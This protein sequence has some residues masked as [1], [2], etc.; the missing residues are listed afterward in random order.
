MQTGSALRI[1]IKIGQGEL[2][3]WHLWLPKAPRAV[4]VETRVNLARL[5]DARVAHEN[6]LTEIKNLYLTFPMS[7]SERLALAFE[8]L[9]QA[10]LGLM[11]EVFDQTLD[12][13]TDDPE[14]LP[15]LEQLAKT[16]RGLQTR[17]PAGANTPL[18]IEIDA[19]L[20]RLLPIE[21]LPFFRP[22]NADD[23]KLLAGVRN[24]DRLALRKLAAWFPGYS[25]TVKRILPYAPARG[26]VLH[27]EPKLPVK[28]FIHHKL[29]G[30][31]KELEFFTK[32]HLCIALDGPW[33]PEGG[34]PGF[35]K[36]NTGRARLAFRH[37][38]RPHQGFDGTKQK[39]ADQVH[40]F[41][42]HCSTALDSS[43]SYFITLAGCKD[44][45]VSITGMDLVAE[46]TRLKTDGRNRAKSH[47][48]P[49]VF[50]NACG[51]GRI[52]PESSFSFPEYFLRQNGNRGFIGT[53][54]PVPDEFAAE[55][56]RKF[57]IALLSGGRNLGWALHRARWQMLE[58]QQNL[59]GLYYIAYADPAM[60]VGRP[61]LE[62]FDYEKEHPET[63][64]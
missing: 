12:E 25:A 33:P 8:R 51:S 10:G 32:N 29:E 58:T 18:L 53:E 43:G 34:G 41:S 44:S 36:T 63:S 21:L 2:L 30:A 11:G 27:N 7:P 24:G 13:K 6:T 56:A 28:F 55:F 31:K 59:L 48:L 1:E 14:S 62:V 39:G 46:Q 60:R 49:L 16:F 20:E 22:K 37:L 4:V 54:T 64:S 40:H 3:V 57:Y 9:L 19:P 50:L 45:E 23:E 17:V 15:P 47:R 5:R 35:P 26:G 42:C 38:R 52:R 61:V